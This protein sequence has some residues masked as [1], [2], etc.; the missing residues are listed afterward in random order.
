MDDTGIYFTEDVQDRIQN[1][2]EDARRQ[3]EKKVEESRARSRLVF[4]ALQLFAF[5]GADA[6]KCQDWMTE[7]LT[8]QM[9]RCDVCVRQY[10]RERRKFKEKLNELVLLHNYGVTS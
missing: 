4:D 6:A 5:D 2:N 7:H 3:R 8:E 1:E 9:Q 10:H